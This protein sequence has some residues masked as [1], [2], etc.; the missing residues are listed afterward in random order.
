MERAGGTPRA[1]PSSAEVAAE[2]DT[3]DLVAPAQREAVLSFPRFDPKRQPLADLRAS[4]VEGMTAALTPNPVP[5]EERMVPGL[6]GEAGPVRILLFRPTDKVGSLPCIVYAH[7][8]G[9]V[10]GTPDMMAGAHAEL[11]ER[12]RALVVS[13][14]YR[15]APE[16]PFPAGLQDVYA[17]LR[18]VH[19]EADALGADP[20]RISVMGDSGGGCLAAAAAIL[21]RDRR[22]VPIKAQFLLYPMLD[23]RTGT[24]DAPADDPGT[25][26]FVWTRPMNRMAWRMVAGDRS[27]VGDAS[28]LLSPAR[29][30]DL[31]GLPPA[32]LLVGALDL[33]R[34]E[35]TAYA[36]RLARSGVPVDSHVFA[37]G[38][39]AFDVLPGEP[40][41][42]M[43]DELARAVTRL[44]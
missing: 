1:G 41:I 12:C 33:F 14:D 36:E 19:D 5:F 43:R 37:G 9:M 20:D 21:C 17:V 8:G 42:R 22:S 16:H 31:S 2:V 10:A 3:I 44:A 32:V 7:G 27:V 13:V 4:V 34:P 28:G 11:A 23:D 6:A 40:G 26:E 18:W 30:G 39:H 29:V 15:L 24:G 25:G 38:V 35:C